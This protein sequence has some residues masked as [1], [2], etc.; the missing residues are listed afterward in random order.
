LYKVGKYDIMNI[1]SN[2]NQEAE[3]DVMQEAMELLKEK[4]YKII[5]E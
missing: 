2:N 1:L 3:T 4:G 5:K